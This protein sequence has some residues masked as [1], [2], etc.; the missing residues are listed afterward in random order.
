M[1]RVWDRTPKGS[2]LRTFILEWMVASMGKSEFTGFV[3]YLPKELLEEVF[4]LLMSF[5][6]ASRGETAHG[7]A[8]RIRAKLLPERM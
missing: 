8:D 5:E 4:V 2:P 6:G 7:F 3:E 1:E